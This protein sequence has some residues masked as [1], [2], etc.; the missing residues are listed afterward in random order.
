MAGRGRKTY[1]RTFVSFKNILRSI[2]GLKPPAR[3]DHG[4]N[5]VQDGM[6][7]LVR[8]PEDDEFRMAIIVEQ[9]DGE[10]EFRPGFIAADQDDMPPKLL[11]V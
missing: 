9:A 2:A 10:R 6:G 1:E 5:L 4:T 8:Q 11:N 3:L 7:H